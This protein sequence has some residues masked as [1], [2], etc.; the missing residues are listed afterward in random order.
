MHYFCYISVRLN[1]LIHF[2][3]ITLSMLKSSIE[4]YTP[5]I[6]WAFL[7]IIA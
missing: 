1:Y 4:I 5:E 7:L 3:D 2:E 6:S